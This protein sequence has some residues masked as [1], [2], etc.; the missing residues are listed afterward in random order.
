MPKQNLVMINLDKL[1][2]EIA[3]PIE[4]N[5]QRLSY[6]KLESR[7]MDNPYTVLLNNADYLSLFKL[8]AEQ[9]QKAIGLLEK[10]AKYQCA[11]ERPLTG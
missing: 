3:E 7:M 11:G 8:I 4:D 9:P 10:V 6:K 5:L 1:V 2:E